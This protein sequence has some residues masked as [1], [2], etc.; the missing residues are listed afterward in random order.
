[1]IIITVQRRARLKEGG[2]VAGGALARAGTSL[3]AFWGGKFEKAVIFQC[4]GW[5]SGGGDSFRGVIM[6]AFV[7]LP[8]GGKF[9][10]TALVQPSFLHFQSE[11]SDSSFFTI[12][13]YQYNCMITTL[14]VLTLY[15]AVNVFAH[16]MRIVFS[17]CLK[18]QNINVR[19]LRFSPRA[20]PTLNLATFSTR[21]STVYAA[22]YL[23]FYTVTSSQVC[24]FSISQNLSSKVKQTI[25]KTR[26][27]TYNS[28]KYAVDYFKSLQV[29]N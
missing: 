25:F 11:Y 6:G 3:R 28:S 29:W 8:R 5:L 14:H 27:P 10:N 20:T 2:G 1:M 19:I 17:K 7:N 26:R 12:N 22:S 9:V 23:I 21:I 13:Y 18:R 4:L 16:S 15:L 24:K